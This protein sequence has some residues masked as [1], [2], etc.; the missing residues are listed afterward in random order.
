MAFINKVSGGSQPVFNLDV[1]NGPIAQTANIATQGP[2][3]PAGPKLDF[4]TFTANAALATQGGVNGFVANVL[5]AIQQTTTVAIAQ[6]TTGTTIAVATYP[7][8][9]FGNVALALAAAQ[10]ANGTI[11]ISSAT[12]TAAFT[13]TA[14]L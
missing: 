11:G 10:S 4:Y 2:F 1:L 12:G 13:N 8:G 7:A 5:Q 6:V 14:D 3:N 9:A